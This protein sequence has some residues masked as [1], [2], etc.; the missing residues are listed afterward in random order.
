M[1]R[2]EFKTKLS[3]QVLLLDGATGTELAKRGLPGGTPPE[4]W[5][6][7]HPEAIIAVHNDYAA[8]GSDIVYAP[9][10]GGNRLKLA[11]SGLEKETFAINR[12]LAELTV[13]NL[14]GKLV[15][16]DMS[17]SGQFV[18]P[19]GELAFE[20]S[21]A[22]YREQAEA[23]VAGGVAGFAVE[24]MLDLQEARAAL[25]GIREVSD[26]PV[27]VTMTFDK[28]GRTLTGCGAVNALL[29]IQELGADAFGCNCSTGPD[30]MAE[31]IREMKPYALIPLVAKPNA[32]M[33]KLVDLKTVFDLGPA[34]FAR[35]TAALVAAGANLVGG[36]CGTTPEH[37]AA[38]AAVVRDLEPVLPVATIPVIAASGRNLVEIGEGTKFGRLEAGADLAAVADLALDLDDGE[39]EVI[40]LVTGLL[41]PEVVKAVLK[42]LAQVSMLPVVLR[43]ANPEAVEAA[44]RFYPGKLVV[45]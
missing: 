20:E 23:L 25:I 36:C 14:P 33:P 40:E 41:G 31:L 8:A 21:V 34:D 30:S 45:V 37:I 26:L 38:L 18:E 6:L 4:S 10:F 12:K 42:E 28:N 7:D 39:N 16:G 43:S 32:G 11:E 2:N 9:T 29:A 27:I 19:V 35:E 15:F 17:P 22:I 44:K 1:T 5:L 13:K 24:T 3:H